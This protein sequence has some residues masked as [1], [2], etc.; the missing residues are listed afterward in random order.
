MG[1]TVT[2]LGCSGSYA[3]PGGACSGYLVDDGATTV[4][5]DAGSGTLA[6]LQLHVALADVDA[7]VLS[8]EHPDH[9]SDLE[10]W[11]NVLRFVLDRRGFPVYA[12]AGLR[13]RAYQDTSPQMAWHDVADGDK[14]TVGTLDFTFSRTDHGPETLGMRV[15]GGGRSLGYSADTGPAWSLEALGGPLDLALCEATMAAEEEGTLQHLSA[16]QAGASA[17]AAGAGRLVLTHLWPT[18]DRERSR[19]EGSE[20]FGSA[21]E[22]AIVGAR[23][24]A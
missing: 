24:Q 9:W 16:R 1:L 6:N 11:N 13:Y 22:V 20:A 12:P 4:W 14:V 18:L 17:R 2:V 5:V 21:V 7:V 10:G 15:D 19:A 8:H 23:Y 3:G